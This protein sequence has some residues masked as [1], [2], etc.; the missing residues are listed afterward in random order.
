MA[1]RNKKKA[2]VARRELYQKFEEETA[3]L[4]TS[5]TYD[6]HAETFKNN[7]EVVIEELDLAD[8]KSVF[9]FTTAIK[10]KCVHSRFVFR[11]LETNRCRYP[12]V[13]HIVCNA[14][15]VSLTG[16]YWW[17]ATKQCCTEPIV[18]LTSPLFKLQ[19]IGERSVND[20][21]YVF[22]CNVFGHYVL[23]SLL[24]I[25][26]VMSKLTAFA[27]VSGVTSLAGTVPFGV[28]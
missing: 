9:T 8:L 4:K 22:Q 13:S 18:A 6:G 16:Y 14:G 10:T 28:N 24:G 1:C 26:Y 20:V 3:R 17:M 23:V 5:G 11:C 21:G 27:S 15:V 19:A 2:E 7:T 12:Y 25:C